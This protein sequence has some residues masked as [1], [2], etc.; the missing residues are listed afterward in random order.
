MGMDA[1]LRN[2]AF[3]EATMKKQI[4][5]AL[6]FL[7][8]VTAGSG[9]GQAA[10]IETLGSPL[11]EQQREQAVSGP[12]PELVV[13]IVTW[14]LADFAL[15]E[16]YRP[17][18][19][20]IVSPTKMAAV[21]YRGLGAGLQARVV[22]DEQW[23]EKM[24][25]TVALYEDATHTIYL[26]EGWTGATPA[27]T[28]VLVHEMVHHLQNLAGEKF[29]CAQAREKPAYAAQKKWLEAAGLDFFQEFE[30]DPVTLMLR[31]VCSF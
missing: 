16:N 1:S 6:A 26:R 13:S 31:T 5:L 10:T 19:I 9:P 4:I 17:P 27:E 15:P 22:T 12:K 25:D 3:E 7:S 21:R 2:S 14:L 23:L 11:V 8:F 28:S 18:R 30:S 29:E 24:R 20:E